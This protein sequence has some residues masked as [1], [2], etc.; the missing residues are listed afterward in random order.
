[1]SPVPPL[2]ILNVSAETLS[3]SAGSNDRKLLS[4]VAAI[5]MLRLVAEGVNVTIPALA[6][7]DPPSTIESAVSEVFPPTAETTAPDAVV[8]VPPDVRL[9]DPEL[10]VTLA[11]MFR[12]PEPEI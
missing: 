12:F 9:T 7:V 6:R 10:E 2:E 1:M 3:I 5:L 8:N 11:F 4:R